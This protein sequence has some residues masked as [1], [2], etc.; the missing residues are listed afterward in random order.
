MRAAAGGYHFRLV[1]ADGQIV[2][3]SKVFVSKDAALAAIESVKVASVSAESVD[4]G[5]GRRTTGAAHS[6]RPAD[7]TADADT[8]EET[9]IDQP[10]PP[11]WIGALSGDQDDSQRVRDLLSETGFG[12]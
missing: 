7:G 2:A 8:G 12:Q 6:P 11:S 5:H 9:I 3:T 10:W 1:A 4:A